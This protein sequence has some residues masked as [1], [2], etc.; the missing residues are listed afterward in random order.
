MG[1]IDTVRDVLSPQ[2]KKDKPGEIDIKRM[3]VVV[4]KIIEDTKVDRDTMTRFLKRYK[5]EWWD[6]DKLKDT[7]STIVANL[8]FSTV[9]TIAPLI[10]DNRP[11]WSLRSRK[12]YLQNYIDGLSVALEYLWDKLDLDMVTFK[13]IL[14]ALIMKVGIVKCWFDPDDGFGGENKVEVVD[15]R[16]FFCAPG[17]D[18]NWDA[19]LQGTRIRK[20]L[21]WIYDKFPD[22]AKDV[23]PDDDKDK[24]PE[25]AQKWELEN[26]YATVYEVWL[27][28]D[29][30]EKY[31]VKVDGDKEIP[32][33]KNDEGAE[34]RSSPSYPYGRLVTFT[35][36]VMLEDKAS[37]YQHSKPPYVFLY[38]YIVPHS[39]IGMGEGD[40]IEEIGKSYNRTLQLFDNYVKY[41]CDPPSFVDTRAGLDIEQLKKEIPAGGGVYAADMSQLPG[42]KVMQRGDLGPL[43][44]AV[45]QYLSG[46]SKLN[47]EISGVTDITKGMTSKSQRQS[48]TEISTLIESSYTRTRQRVRNFEWSI[49]RLLYIILCNTQQ[50]YTEPRDFSMTRDENIDYY[51]IGSSKAQ[52]EQTIGTPN[53]TKQPG[54]QQNSE[55]DDAQIEKDY[56]QF[57]EEWGDVDVIYADFDLDIQTNSTL[58]MDKQSLANLFLRL[59]EMAQANPVT[60]MPMWE[61]ALSALRIPKYKQIIAKMNELFSQQNQAQQQPAESPET[62]GPAGMMEMIQRSQA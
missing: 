20:P 45:P 34:E 7:D 42:G 22:K 60:G 35:K 41:H 11:I 59:L 50:F 15:P 13:W 25:N 53:A 27:K 19:P 9:M 39:L 33:K 43:D 52:V 62:G 38:D 14:D 6:T 37:I 18:D 30:A 54:E 31:F 29:T 16:L 21:S 47:E 55:D 61:A 17:Y 3:K 2:K 46:L 51:T 56:Q 58:P 32:A 44:Q 57:I 49:K 48:A 36:D 23:K 8:F 24:F 10:T 28:D 40:Q 1:M 5:G 26:K 4:D 12:P